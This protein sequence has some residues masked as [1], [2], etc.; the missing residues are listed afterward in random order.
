MGKMFE[1]RWDRHN[2]YATSYWVDIEKPIIIFDSGANAFVKYA[3]LAFEDQNIVD[4]AEDI[5]EEA[6]NQILAFGGKFYEKL[7]YNRFSLLRE[8]KGF[9]ETVYSLSDFREV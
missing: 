8:I 4:L 1:K 9:G 5:F 3:D 2:G 6:F 7:N